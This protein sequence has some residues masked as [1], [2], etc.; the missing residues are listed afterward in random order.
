MKTALAYC[1]YMI[2]ATFL[3]NVVSAGV[4]FY[5]GHLVLAGRMSAGSLVSFMLYQQSL[6][7]SFQVQGLLICVA[8]KSAFAAMQSMCRLQAHTMG[9]LQLCCSH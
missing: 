2:T 8:L 1:T 9:T 6:S 4:L 7:S 3:P 5:G